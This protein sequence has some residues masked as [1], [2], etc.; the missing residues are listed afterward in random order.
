MSGLYNSAASLLGTRG[1]NSNWIANIVPEVPNAKKPAN[2]DVK[3]SGY[4]SASFDSTDGPKGKMDVTRITVGS[5]LTGNVGGVTVRVGGGFREKITNG[6]KTVE[7]LADASAKFPTPLGQATV[8]GA[9]KLDLITG[10]WELSPGASLTFKTPTGDVKIAGATTFNMQTGVMTKNN[11]Q[12]S[13]DLN[14][15]TALVFERNFDKKTTQYGVGVTY[16]FDD[17]KLALTVLATYNEDTKKISAQ[18]QAGVSE[19]LCVKRIGC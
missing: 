3:G 2:N 15:Q 5:N 10:V 11:Q 4:A 19:F 8:Q 9:A 1:I 17:P 13:L 18:A 7:F 6:N 12:I 14:K 16:K